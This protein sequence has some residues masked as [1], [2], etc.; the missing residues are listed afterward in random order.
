MEAI[1]IGDLDQLSQA[2]A[3]ASPCGANLEYDPDF[4]ALERNLQG[5]REEQYGALIVPAIAPDWTLVQQ[6]SLALLSRSR[7]LR[8]AMPLTRALLVLR[9]VAGLADGLG[10]IERLLSGHWDS[11]HP[12]LDADD[13]NDATPRMNAIAALADSTGMLRD[14]SETAFVVL[15]A[16]G[17]LTLR[18]LDYASGELTPPAGQSALTPGA[19]DAALADVAPATLQ[20]ALSAI[21]LA[22]KCAVRIEHTLAQR[23]GHALTPT[24]AP[25]QAA[26]RRMAAALAGRAEARSTPPVEAHAADRTVTM[27][28]GP[29]GPAA[30][31]IASREDVV[32]MLERILAYYQ[33]HEPSSPIPMLLERARRLA[34][35]NFIEIMEDLAPDSLDQLLVIRGRQQ[36]Q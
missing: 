14:L 24:L 1:T 33:Q 7:D 34:P 8:L 15:P 6:Q 19:I 11:V 18:Q 25:M 29:P 16:L 2:L 36:V 22:A 4:L 21:E 23:A 26:L 10:L 20:A 17:P 5:K 27:A 28:P 13:G 12:E 9:G 32:R 3:G 30:A 31:T 35:K